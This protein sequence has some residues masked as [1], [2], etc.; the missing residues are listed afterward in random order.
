MASSKFL[1]RLGYGL[2]T[3]LGWRR[4]G[5]FIP[6]RYADRMPAG[7]GVPTA[8]WEAW[9]GA[10]KPAFAAVLAAIDRYGPDLLPLIEAAPPAPRFRQDWFP[11]LDG[12]AA[13]TLVRTLRPGRIVEI[14]SGHSTRFF[15]RAI[16]DQGLTTA[17]VAIDP[18]P[19]ADLSRLPVTLIQDTVQTVDPGVFETLGPGDLLSVDSSHIAMPGTDVDLVANAILPRLPAGVLV[20]IHDIFLPDPYPASWAWRAYNEQ[21]V[22]AALLTGGGFTPLFAS[23][24]VATRMADAV[25]ATVLDRLPLPAGAS[26]SSLWL[27]KT[28]DPLFSPTAENGMP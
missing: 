12:A 4:R 22:V 11:R 19:R 8:A 1:R 3:V 2:A 10:G 17:L 26:E 7:G 15:A 20:H 13:Y 25:A 5:F 14:G 23:R 9:F 21:T 28:A 18:A 16:R 24:Y 27:R 6:Y